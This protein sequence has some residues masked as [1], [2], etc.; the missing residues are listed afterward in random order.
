MPEI[1]LEELECLMTADSVTI[2]DVREEWEYRRAHVAGVIN[3]PLGR[4]PLRYLE[5]PKDK[6]VMVIC[7]HGNRSLVGAEFL[8]RNGFEGVASVKGGTMAWLASR[9]PV[10]KD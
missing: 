1:G 4:L 3:I 5:I 2:V 8:V 6:R 7:E 9:R 10:E